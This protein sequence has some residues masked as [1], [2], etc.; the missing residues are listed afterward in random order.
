MSGGD[1]D[2]VAD[3]AGDDLL[4]PGVRTVAAVGVT[5]TAGLLK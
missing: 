5:G 1:E 3:V 2:S 4:G